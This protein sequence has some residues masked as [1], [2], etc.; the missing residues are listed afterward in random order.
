MIVELMKMEVVVMVM[1]DGV[2][3]MIDCVFGMVVVVG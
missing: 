3:E 1:E 2:I